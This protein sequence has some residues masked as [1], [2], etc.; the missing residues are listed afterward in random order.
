MKVNSVARDHSDPKSDSSVDGD[1][2][3]TGPTA[4][5][6]A[7]DGEAAVQAGSLFDDGLGAAGSVYASGGGTGKGEA[8]PSGSRSGSDATSSNDVAPLV[9]TAMDDVVRDVEAK[10]SKLSRG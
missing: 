9:H 7:T 5:P 2:S 3:A 6:V 8:R 4:D 1:A 10:A